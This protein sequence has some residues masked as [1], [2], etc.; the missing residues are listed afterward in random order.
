MDLST[1]V[2]INQRY[3]FLFM[4]LIYSALFL[5]F[6]RNIK[7]DK[8]SK[9]IALVWGKIISIVYILNFPLI[10]YFYTKP[11]VNFE[12]FMILIISVYS[13]SYLVLFLVFNVLTL[14]FIAKLTKFLTGYD[15]SKKLRIK[16]KW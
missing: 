9:A 5:F 11:E 6:T 13:I 2:E 7:L 4:V 15:L 14:E 10:L 16:T 1:I 8:I 3:I 12:G